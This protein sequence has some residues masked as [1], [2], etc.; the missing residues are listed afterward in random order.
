MYSELAP[1]IRRVRHAGR[2]RGIPHGYAAGFRRSRHDCEPGRN[3][4]GKRT[5][6]GGEAFDL[7]PCLDASDQHQLKNAQAFER[8]GAARI[9]LDQEM[10]GARLVEEVT[11]LIGSPGLLEKMGTS[12]KASRNRGR[13]GRAAKIWNPCVPIAGQRGILTRARKPK[14]YIIK[15]FFKPQPVHFI[16]IGGIGMSGLA[17]VLLDLGYPVTGSDQKLSPTTDRLAARGA[18]IY[19]GHA[20]GN[21]GGAKAVVVSSAVRRRIRKCVE[22]RRPQFR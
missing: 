22:A 17:E 21:L 16:G 7:V 19:E 13:R 2:D 20:A 18:L 12:A 6:G 3:G 11:Q 14:Q 15:M 9:V 4:R 5:G 8:G 1:K 10:T